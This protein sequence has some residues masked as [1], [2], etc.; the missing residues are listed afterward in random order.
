VTIEIA[1]KSLSNSTQTV[2]IRHLP[3]DPELL[4]LLDASSP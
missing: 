4:K 2:E 3:N 1:F